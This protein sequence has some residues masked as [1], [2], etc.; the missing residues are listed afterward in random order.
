[1]TNG[2]SRV[3]ACN[4]I[5]A[6]E[7]RDSARED[8]W[9]ST[10]VRALSDF[11]MNFASQ[12]GVALLISLILYIVIGLPVN[13]CKLNT[14]K[15]PPLAGLSRFWLWRQSVRKTVHIAQKEALEKYGEF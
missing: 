6:R 1:M 7:V 3:G 11:T 13:Y 2:K 15:G 10:S 5:Y 4:C 12:A 9:S 8:R 14:F